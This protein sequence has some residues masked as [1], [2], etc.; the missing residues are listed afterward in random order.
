MAK[1]HAPQVTDQQLQEVGPM[2]SIFPCSESRILDHMIAMK[3]FDYSIVD[4]ADIS[5]VGIKTTLRVVHSLESEK[6]LLRT[7]N[8]GR[9][10]MFK[11]N[12]N[13]RRGKTLEKLAFQIADKKIRE[14]AE[15]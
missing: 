13:S 2:A 10:I 8:V 1:R 5:G 11:L 15:K 14:M 7:R 6:I 3:E 9:A 4:I 12:P